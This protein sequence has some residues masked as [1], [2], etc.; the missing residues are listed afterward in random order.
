MS[1][2]KNHAKRSRKTYRLNMVAARGALR[3]SIPWA[4]RMSVAEMLKQLKQPNP[5]DS[6]EP[7]I[8]NNEEET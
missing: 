5:A 2:K 4:A 7:V 6:D 8:L 1:S 3:G